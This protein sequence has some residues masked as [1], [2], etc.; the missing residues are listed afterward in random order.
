M[1]LVTKEKAEL[2][3]SA[4]VEYRARERITQ[5]ELAE[6]CGLAKNTIQTVENGVR[7]PTARTYMQIKLVVQPTE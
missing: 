5:T 2:L 7:V 1:S 6:R 4:M 3:Q